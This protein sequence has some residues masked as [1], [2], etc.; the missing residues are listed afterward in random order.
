MVLEHDTIEKE[1]E[2]F[3]TGELKKLRQ[4]TKGTFEVISVCIYIN[5]LFIFFKPQRNEICRRRI[6]T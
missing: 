6:L 1:T 5:P 3:D 2:V 4:L